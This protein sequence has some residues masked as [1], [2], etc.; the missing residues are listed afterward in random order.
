MLFKNKPEMRMR[1]AFIFAHLPVNCYITHFPSNSFAN[2]AASQPTT[3]EPAYF[4]DPESD[5]DKEEEEE[6]EEYFD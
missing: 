2:H 3:N 6:G 5:S 4:S 1:E